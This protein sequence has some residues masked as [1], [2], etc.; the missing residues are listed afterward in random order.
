MK[1]MKVI[2]HQVERCG[3]PGY[4]ALG[5]NQQMRAAPKLEDGHLGTAEHSAHSKCEH[6]LGA[7]RDSIALKDNVPDPDFRQ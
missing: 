7:L 4:G 5:E 2:D 3:S 1:R 6:E